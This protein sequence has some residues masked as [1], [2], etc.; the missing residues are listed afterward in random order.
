VALHARLLL[1][2][3]SSVV[4]ACSGHHV[5]PGSCAQPAGVGVEQSAI[6]GGG[7]GASYIQFD[8]NEAAAIG[9]VRFASAGGEVRCSG[10]L[11]QSMWVLTAAHCVPPGSSGTVTFGSRP[12][13]GRLDATLR[14]V[15]IHPR[16]DAALLGLEVGVDGIPPLHVFQEDDIGEYVGGLAQIAGFGL[17]NT[18]AVGELRFA[19]E[20][21]IKIAATTITGQSLSGSGGCLGDSGGPLIVRDNTGA[22]SVL[23][24]LSEGSEACD[25]TDV[26]LRTDLLRSWIAQTTGPL[27]E[28]DGG[29][30]DISAEG[31]CFNGLA[32]WCDANRRREA[33]RCS[34]STRCGWAFEAG[35]Y[36]CVRSDP[37]GGVDGQGACDANILR[38]CD[39]GQLYTTSCAICGG[40]C[41]VSGADAVARCTL[42]ATR[43]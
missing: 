4:V 21:V 29:C 8:S 32:V 28:N 22:P 16:W 19:V 15:V 20:T 34:A 11:V 14:E 33:Q 1:W 24:L 12:D 9:L 23:G 39:A 3:S 31:R 7:P 10:F 2:L 18:S 26:Y 13:G 40:A 41:R 42:P 30:G 36:R 25:Q 27:P 5:N 17:T 38:R 6:F 35:G 43:N 37:C